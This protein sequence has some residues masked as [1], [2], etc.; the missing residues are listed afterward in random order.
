MAAART[1]PAEHLGVEVDE[2]A[3]ALALVADDRRSRLQP[4]ETRQAGSSEHCIHARTG[5]AG[6]PGKDMGLDAQLSPAS[7][8]LLD[9]FGRMSSGLAVDDAGAVD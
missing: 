1:D 5:Q 6:L 4:I 7:A 8:E 9:E 3:R 2:L